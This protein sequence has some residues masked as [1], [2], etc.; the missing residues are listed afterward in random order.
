[1]SVNII[2]ARLYESIVFSTS[3][4]LSKSTAEQ[5]VAGVDYIPKQDRV[6]MNNGV[7][8][9]AVSVTIKHVR[10]RVAISF[11]HPFIDNL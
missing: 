9:S 6:Y 10:I 3:R 7:N 5:A 11:I 2:V 8:R 4:D 1:M